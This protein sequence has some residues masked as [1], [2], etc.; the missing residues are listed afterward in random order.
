MALAHCID[1]ILPSLALVPKS[2]PKL[3]KDSKRV[4]HPQREDFFRC[5]HSTASGHGTTSRQVVETSSGG[6]SPAGGTGGEV[7]EDER[8]SVGSPDIPHA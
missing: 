2:G 3:L 7:E 6:I 1:A 4:R 8:G 5:R